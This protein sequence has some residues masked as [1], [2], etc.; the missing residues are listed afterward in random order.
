MNE[1]SLYNQI[2]NP[3]G[4]QQVKE[5]AKE[6]AK[7]QLLGVNSESQG[8]V[9]LLAC[10]SQGIDPLTFNNRYN[11]IQGKVAI[12]TDYLHSCF[13]RSGGSVSWK[14]TTNEK[15][16]A[17]F[18]H[19][20]Y[21]PNGMT[22]TIT[23]KELID[24]G[25]ALDRSGN[26]KTNYKMHCA[27]MLRARVL[28]AGIRAIAPMITDGYYVESEVV[29]FTPADRVLDL[30]SVPTVQG[31]TQAL[32]EPEPEPEPEPVSEPKDITEL[33]IEKEAI[34]NNF[35]CDKLHWI[36]GEQTWRNL[37]PRH[38]DSI[39]QRTAQFLEK[40]EAYFKEQYD[41]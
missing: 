33:L 24:S 1:I 17:E 16:T 37:A 7:S 4:F 26:L 39:K 3:N 2:L 6:L 31:T 23:L 19:K 14:I 30:G 40:A 12:K 34:V 29:D 18:K 38:M 15:C 10:I 9:L 5:L 11:I 20:T 32:P 21:C 28:S 36:A 8:I 22:I 25:V 41:E 35:L 13:L 27:A